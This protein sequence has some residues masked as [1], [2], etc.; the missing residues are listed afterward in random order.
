MIDPT[1][2]MYAHLAASTTV[3]AALATYE[4]LPAIFEELA[5]NG[6]DIDEPVI[7]IDPPHSASRDDTSTRTGRALDMRLRVYARVS[8]ENGATGYVALNDAAEALALALHNSQPVVNGGRTSRVAVSGPHSAP[9]DTPNIG[10]R[11]I[12]IRWN[13]TEN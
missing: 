3:T 8:D 4:N 10:G 9:T 12:S 11:V 7:I 2:A 5:P 13:I 6:Y 1:A